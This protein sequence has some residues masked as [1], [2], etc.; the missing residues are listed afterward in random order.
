MSF[1]ILR[2]HTNELFSLALKGI[3]ARRTEEVQAREPPQ[4][5]GAPDKASSSRQNLQET[6]YEPAYNPK[7]SIGREDSSNTAVPPRPLRDT[8]SAHP[9]LL[10][11]NSQESVPKPK[12]SLATAN[13]GGK[14]GL[15]S[16]APAT[17]T[18]TSRETTPSQPPPNTN[19]STASKGGD[20]RGM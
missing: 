2:S 18:F 1:E 17:Q 12:V 15:S 14:T 11:D 6:R 20:G 7:S 19:V 3:A 5:S 10:Q 13:T 8:A 16:L 4:S 9:Y